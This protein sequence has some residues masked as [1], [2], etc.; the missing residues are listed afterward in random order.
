M[1]GYDLYNSGDWDA[2]MDLFHPDVVV[3]R[4]G[5]Q[6]S[7][8]GRENVRAFM[9]PD[10]FEYQMLEPVEM[11]R[12]ASKVLV[13]VRIRAKGRASEMELDMPGWHVWTLGDDVVTELLATFDEKKA[14]TEAGLLVDGSD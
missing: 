12:S 13:R 2:L 11:T 8:H 4:D 1:R 7:L 14:R 6:A 5:N 9:E 10:A 3:H